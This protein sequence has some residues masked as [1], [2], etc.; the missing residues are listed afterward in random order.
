MSEVR[1]AIELA[2]M[3]FAGCLSGI[4]GRMRASCSAPPFRAISAAL[5]TAKCVGTCPFGDKAT[6]LLGLVAIPIFVQLV[7]ERA[8]DPHSVRCDL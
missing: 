3:R 2:A 6:V 5:F 4:R 8:H 1:C 7:L